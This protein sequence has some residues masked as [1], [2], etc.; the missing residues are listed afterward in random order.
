V[1]AAEGQRLTVAEVALRWLVHHSLMSREAG[2]A[3]IVG[4]SSGGHLE[5]NLADLEK[6][7]LP[8]AAQKS[9]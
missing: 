6:G 5:N 2:D 7:P 1:R 3:V 9:A 8:R 4:A